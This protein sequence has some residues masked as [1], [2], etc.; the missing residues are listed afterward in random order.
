[1]Q[2]E[3]MSRIAVLGI[4]AMGS[5]MAV[6]L[7]KAGHEI[8]VWN[9]SADRTV[10]LIEAGARAADTPRDA[11]EKAEFVICMVRDDDASRYVW[12]DPEAGAIASLSRNTIAI[13]SSTITVAWAR[14]LATH[15]HRQGVAF[16]D[17]PVAGSR[18]Q[19]D[20][21][22]LIYFV[23]GDAETVMKAE[24]ILK[25]MGNAVHHAGPSGSGA[26]IKLAVN[27]LY[28]VQVA[29]MGELL[30]L[31]QRCGVDEAKAVEIL[32]ST[33]VC[34]LAAKVAIGAMLTRNFAP[35]FPIELVEKDFGY[36]LDT[37]KLN[38]AQVPMART[39]RQVFAEAIG[40]GHSGDNITGVA[41]LYL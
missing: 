27:A 15:C 28:G 33:P 2:G 5:R 9:R 23:G 31:M 10:P 11:V 25:T 24:P 32:S 29:A 37:A 4:G 20:A 34:S 35:L 8:A 17:A 41:Q 30:G 36:V 1:M 14:E 22:Q 6:A 38:G 18:P 39:G 3:M 13:E 16:L 26:A 21:A 40:Q 12:L 7:L 19:A